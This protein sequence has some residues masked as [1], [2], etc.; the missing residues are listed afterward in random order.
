MRR[1]LRSISHMGLLG[2]LLWLAIVGAGTLAL[3]PTAYADT[4]PKPSAD[5]E[6]EYEIDRVPI[7]EGQLLECDD[8]DC[9][10][11]HPLRELGPQRFTCD[12][13]SCTS[14]AYGYARYLKLVITFEDQVRESSV[15]EKHYFEAVFVVTVTQSGLEVREK[16]IIITEEFL[17]AL[18]ITLLSETL[19]GFFFWWRY[20]LPIRQ[21]VWVPTASLITLPIIWFGFTRLIQN[22]Y[23]VIVLGEVF[24]VIFEAAFLYAITRGR[25]TRRQ[26]IILSLTM[27]AASFLLGLCG[28]LYFLDLRIHR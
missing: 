7:I 13:Y 18:I 2:A 17:F 10:Q 6:F 15:F 12:D 5:F 21:L 24:A 4:G 8:K 19:V 27:N 14:L 3:V 25:L 16:D 23:N 26:A 28:P 11:S 1:L 22:D 20:A 9:T